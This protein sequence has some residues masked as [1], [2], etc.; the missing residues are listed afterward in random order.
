MSVAEKTLLRMACAATLLVAALA[1]STVRSQQK[2]DNY[3]RDR[4]R[5]ILHDA[6]DN[7]KKH[8][9]DTKFHNLDLDARFHQFDQK[10]VDATSLSQSFGV[11]AAFLDG[12]ND[13]HTFFT[14]P[15]RPYR[16]DYGYRL[17]MYGNDCYVTRVRPGTDAE[18]KVHPGDQV[19]GYNKFNVTRE[20]FWKM[21]YYF[22]SLAP[23]RGSVLE[24]RDPS[25]QSRQLTID[26][27]VRELKKVLD[28]T[29]QDGGSDFWDLVRQEESSDHIV[30]QRWVDAGDVMIW[31][32]PEFFV[33][34]HEVDRIFNDA[35]KHKTLI[36]DLRGNPGGAVIT[37]DRMVANL[38]DHE[39]KIADRVGRKELKPEIAKTRGGD[40]FTGQLIVLVDSI[41]ASCAELFARLMQLEHRGTVLG[42]RTAGAVMEARHYP[43]SQGADTKI[44]YGFSV[45]EADLTMKDGKSLEHAGVTPDEIMIP[46]AQDLAS[47]KDP[48]LARALE[49]AGH[50]VDPVAAG[51]MFPFEWL[52]N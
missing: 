26:A 31:K 1:S 7:V 40:I 21:T 6:Y 38:F 35:R 13:S 32:M 50:K 9:Y 10:I 42:D 49:L 24:I 36:L 46:T 16:M 39:V 22:N 25:G 29:G 44:F 15:A 18:T 47:G 45:T 51:K 5:A 52:P 20:V 2:M 23:Q 43:G 4:A 30:R 17:Q 41:S 37:L 11:I 12:L 19:L 14:P 27:K 3:N 28:L 34:D 8:Y 33:E 48:V